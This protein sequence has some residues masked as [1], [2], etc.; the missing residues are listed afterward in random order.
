[1]NIKLKYLPATP[2]DHPKSVAQM[3]AFKAGST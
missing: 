2:Q 3:S 1:M